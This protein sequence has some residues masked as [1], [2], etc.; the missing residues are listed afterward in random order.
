MLMALMCQ[1]HAA[2]QSPV[3]SKLSTTKLSKLPCTLINSSVL[4]AIDDDFNL[5]KYQEQMH[6]FFT[7]LGTPLEFQLS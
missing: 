2:I 4:Q 6:Q 7:A 1:R 3:K 5:V